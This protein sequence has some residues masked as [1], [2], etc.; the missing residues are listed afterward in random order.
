MNSFEKPGLS[1]KVASTEHS[2]PLAALSID[3]DFAHMK[4]QR[5]NAMSGEGESSLVKSLRMPN[6]WD[7]CKKVQAG[8]KKKHGG[9]LV[10]SE[11]PCLPSAGSRSN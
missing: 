9:L 6:K 4:N 5:L 7:T 10:F 3:F 1:M 11:L 8:N 2:R